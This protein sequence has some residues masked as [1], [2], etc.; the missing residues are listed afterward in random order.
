MHGARC[1]FSCKQFNYH[2]AGFLPRALAVEPS[3]HLRRMDTGA[4]QE[5]HV[6]TPVTQCVTLAF[7]QKQCPAGALQVS[8]AL[9]PKSF[10]HQADGHWGPSGSSWCNASY[11]FYVRWCTAGALQVFCALTVELLGL[12]EMEAAHPGPPGDGGGVK[13]DLVVVGRRLGVLLQPLP[14]HHLCSD[15]T[16]RR[17]HICG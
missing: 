9:P 2:T 11:T 12:R 7:Y 15:N 10:W 3:G 4:S 14:P 13:E 16:H 5:A 17:G 1:A 8:W 6:A